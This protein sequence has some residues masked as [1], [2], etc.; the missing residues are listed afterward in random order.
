MRFGL[1]ANRLHRQ[2][3]DG[4]LLRWAKAYEDSI[5]SLNLKLHAVGGTYDAL[6]R[7][8]VLSNSGSLVRLP[9]GVE[10]GVMRLASCI[11][12]GLTTE[13]EL[14]GV[15]YLVDPVDPSSLYPETQAL[16]RQCVI[17]GKPFVST[18]AGA[19]EWIAV[20]LAHAGTG[21]AGFGS[22]VASQ[23][24]ALIAHDAFKDQMVEFAA[25]HFDLLSRFSSRV[26]TGTTGGLLNDMALARGWPTDR[27]WVT[28]YR[29]GPMGGDAQI[30]ELVLN[31]TC[32]KV[33][34]F[35][36]P[37]VARQHEADIQLLERAVS[38]ATQ[39]TTCFNSPAM[40]ARWAAA[41][42]L[43]SSQ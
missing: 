15:I 40:A 20:E 35:E 5:R 1:V 16:K 43:S 28:R 24:V 10:G 3:V 9:S 38:T 18:A 22:S 17:H 11:A 25:A 4:A 12:G 13:S 19:A 42:Q 30:A 6:A 21:D 32:S 34:F 39:D 26:G 14:D 7:E 31:R 8:G 41:I 2:S 23:T 27:P 36:D 37:H 29:S 33:I